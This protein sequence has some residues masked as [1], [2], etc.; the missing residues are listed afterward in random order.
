MQVLIPP[1]N[2]MIVDL[3]PV[4]DKTPGGVLLPDSAVEKPSR[5]TV[6]A[7]GPGIRSIVTGERIPMEV[8]IG[9]RVIVRK[10]AGQKVT[11]DDG[12]ERTLYSEDNILAILREVEEDSA[13]NPGVDG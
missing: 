5:G 13:V 9:D 6:T 11:M 10:L 8:K 12:T 2:K 4:E 3:D 7:V 1:A